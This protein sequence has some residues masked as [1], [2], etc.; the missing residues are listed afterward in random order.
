MRSAVARASAAR[1]NFDS[2]ELHWAASEFSMWVTAVDDLLVKK[3]S[4]YVAR[5]QSDQGGVA[6]RGLRWARN[7]Q[8]HQLIEV[9]RVSHGGALPMT[10]PAFLGPVA[11]W[12]PR[13]KLPPPGRPQMLDTEVAYDN[14]LAGQD[15][16]PVLSGV[17][18]FLSDRAVP[19]ENLHP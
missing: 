10:L 7:Q 12:A 5:R 18:Q 15:V 3:D 8:I 4:L 2:T 1:I 6:I 14:H 16:L 9:H 17:M 11:R 19:G 13:S